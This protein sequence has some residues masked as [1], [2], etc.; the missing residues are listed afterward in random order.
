M[1]LFLRR[2]EAQPNLG[3]LLALVDSLRGGTVNP[4]QVETAPA[5]RAGL[6]ALAEGYANAVVPG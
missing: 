2:V 4:Q 1:R 6:L 3:K 5:L